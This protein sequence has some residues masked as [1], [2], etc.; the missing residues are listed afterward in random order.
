[1]LFRSRQLSL[2]MS[3]SCKNLLKNES[4]DDVI[5]S[6]HVKCQIDA[7][8]TFT[9]RVSVRIYLYKNV[10]RNFFFWI[11]F[12]NFFLEFFLET[13]LKYV[14]CL[15]FLLLTVIKRTSTWIIIWITKSLLQIRCLILFSIFI[16]SGNACINTV[17][18]INREWT[19]LKTRSKS[20]KAFSSLQLPQ[21]IKKSLEKKFWLATTVCQKKLFWF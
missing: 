12:W 19:S 11:F 17:K 9:S 6:T 5:M 8:T 4:I 15:L 20:S 18:S 13:F 7:L 1:V 21:K 16:Y 14:L 10:F 3:R 2:Y